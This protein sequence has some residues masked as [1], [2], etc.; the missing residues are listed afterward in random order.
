MMK[1]QPASSMSAKLASL[2]MPASAITVT[3]TIP[4][5]ATNRGTS[6][7]IVFV[8]ARLPS[9]HRSSTASRSHR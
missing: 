5:A 6:G 8:S 7:I 9:T 1:L 4:C 2:I 3:S